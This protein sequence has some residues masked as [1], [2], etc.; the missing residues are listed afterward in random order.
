LYLKPEIRHV[1]CAD[2]TLEPTARARR[3][4]MPF[5]VEALFQYRQPACTR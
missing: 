3:I 1:I 2:D 4:C 5:P